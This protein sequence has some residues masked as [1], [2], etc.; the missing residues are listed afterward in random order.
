MK[1]IGEVATLL[2]VSID[3]L[4]YYEKIDLLNDV[5]RNHSGTR[6]YSQADIAKIQFIKQAKKMNFSLDEVKQLLQ[7]RADPSHVKPQIREMAAQKLAA[8]NANITALTELRDQMQRLIQAC[9]TSDDSCP[10]IDQLNQ[11]S[12]K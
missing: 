1:K 4:R 9:Q 11:G 8:I 6:L 5:E 3:T 12:K 7:F 2:N 10:I